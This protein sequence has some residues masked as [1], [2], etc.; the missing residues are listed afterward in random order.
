[1]D[2]LKSLVKK[3]RL[4]TSFLK[5]NLL[6]QA[7]AEANLYSEEQG[8]ELEEL[9]RDNPVAAVE[10]LLELIRLHSTYE[11]FI[12]ALERSIEIGHS[13]HS[14]VVDAQAHEQL[15]NEIVGSE[16][17]KPKGL[18][19]KR[20]IDIGHSQRTTVVDAPAHEQPI[21]ENAGEKKPKG[22]KVSRYTHVTVWGILIFF[23]MKYIALVCS[24]QGIKVHN[25]FKSKEKKSKESESKQHFLDKNM[26]CSP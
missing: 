11:A 25:L 6:N 18:I 24:G 13:Q 23:T 8:R 20:S 14:T 3:K 5:Y 2:P 1:M 4:F 19:L 17:K 22:F 26:V 12:Q 16:E 15:I 10:R 21:N 7:A 9:A